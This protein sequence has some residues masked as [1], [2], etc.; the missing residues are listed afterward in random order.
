M[1]TVEALAVAL[2]GTAQTESEPVRL[3][4]GP[5]SVEFDGGGLRYVCYGGVEVIRAISFLARD[6]NWGTHALKLDDV[7]IEQRDDAFEVRFRGTC[8]PGGTELQLDASIVGS[9]NGQLEFNAHATLAGDLLTNRTGFVVLHPLDVSGKPVVVET[10]DGQRTSTRFP[11]KIDPFQP[12]RDIRAL[13]TQHHDA[14]SVEVRM[15]GDT[16]EMEDQRNWSD[17]S[18]KTYVRPLALPWPYTLAKGSTLAQSVKV[19][20]RA[21]QPA[22]ASDTTPDTAAAPARIRLDADA[23]EQRAVPQL[24]IGV[25]AEDLDTALQHADALHALNP[26][27]FVAHLDLR[28]DDPAKVVPRFAQLADTARVPYVLEVVLTGDGNPADELRRVA[29]AAS[30]QPAPL[31][32]QVSPAPDLKAVLPGSPW[33][34]CPSFDDIFAAARAAFPDTPLGGG[35]FAYF[36]ELNRKRPPFDKLD[37]ATFTTCP[38][39]HAAD[40]RS[41]METLA[42]LPFIA[43]SVTALAGKTPYRVGPGT[44]ASRDNPYGAAT[45]PNETGRGAKRICLTD[46]DP[47]QR[48]LY[49]AAWNLGYFAAFAA[50]GATHIALSELTGPRGLLDSGKPTPLFR[51]LASLAQ[52]HGAYMAPLEV[53]PGRLPLAAFAAKQASMTT[54]WIANLSAKTNPV[55]LDVGGTASGKTN[56]ETHGA[57]IARWLPGVDFADAP[58][59]HAPLTAGSFK[60]EP[61]ETAEIHLFA[62]T[63]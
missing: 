59:Q 19:I 14:L 13:T 5:L 12:F 57:T 60:L 24:G 45:L 18:F 21:A 56:G 23:R 46:N 10:V 1:Q 54:L 22:S 8:G 43:N 32:L 41:V 35:T 3:A 63:S 6:E 29:A 55:E 49:G 17:A 50:G 28:H 42:T 33:P 37:Y 44:I 25:R 31:A 61:Y 48:A 27:Y 39:V 16:F 62:S 20:V 52:T 53:E 11:E 7:Q 2:T 58:P 34:P 4:A 40:D 47:R 38:I 30:G 26:A 9:A 51:L 36:T 15:E